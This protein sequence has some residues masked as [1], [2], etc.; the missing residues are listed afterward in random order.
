MQDPG[1]TTA[2]SRQ[3]VFS[4]LVALDSNGAAS[5][6]LYVDDGE[7]IKNSGYVFTATGQ[8]LKLRSTVKPVY[9]DQ[10]IRT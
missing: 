7:S 2:E 6:D 1:L 4:L 3:N 10:T 9:S 8:T 5:G